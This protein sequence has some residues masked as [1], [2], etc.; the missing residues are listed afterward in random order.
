MLRFTQFIKPWPQADVSLPY[1]HVDQGISQGNGLF[2]SEREVPLPWLVSWILASF[3][4]GHPCQDF[5]PWF[6]WPERQQVLLPITPTPAETATALPQGR[7]PE[8]VGKLQIVCFLWKY[9]FLF[10]SKA[11]LKF[12]QCTYDLIVHMQEIWF[13]GLKTSGT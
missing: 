6:L 12:S 3:S 4:G 9:A 13:L 10:V 1:A 7:D 2:C 11:F 5:F 8:N